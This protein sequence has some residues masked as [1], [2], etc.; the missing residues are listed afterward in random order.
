MKDHHIGGDHLTEDE[1]G[2]SSGRSRTESREPLPQQQQPGRTT[3]PSAQQPVDCCVP[4]G[5]HSVTYLSSGRTARG[6]GSALIAVFSLGLAAYCLLKR[7]TVQ[8]EHERGGS[9]PSRT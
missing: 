7:R 9:D 5:A 8:R 6:V 4:Y 2:S 3:N 1:G